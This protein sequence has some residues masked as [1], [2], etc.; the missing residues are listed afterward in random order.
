[1]RR[2]DVPLKL[3]VKPWLPIAAAT[4]SLGL[5]AHLTTAQ[6][7]AQNAPVRVLASRGVQ[8]V[9]EE[10]RAQA[11]TAAGHKTTI[12]FSSSTDLKARI[13]TGEPFD[14]AI[15]TTDLMDELVKTGR[16]AAGTRVE[17]ARAGIGVGIRAG[18]PKPDI[19]TSDALKQALLKAKAVTYAQ[20]GASRVHVEKM[21]D[22]M[23]IKAEMA[24]K[25]MLEQ[26]SV[27]ATARVAD[28]GA[29]LVLTLIS[30]ILPA[31]G[32]ELL[33]PLP[34]EHQNY[35]SFAAGVGAKAQDAAS[36]KKLGQ[37]LTKPD[38]VPVLKAK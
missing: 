33:G 12:Q 32:V 1:M 7:P 36:A 13:E 24:R 20:D 5:L 9:I 28:G 6:T 2:G 11:E 35:V 18:V 19:K 29:D 27:R 3:R 8:A 10:L 16:A 34:P 14:A 21:F 25:T 31:K 23:G 17:V 4:A 22:R 30:E 37:F 15:V 38:V 26:C